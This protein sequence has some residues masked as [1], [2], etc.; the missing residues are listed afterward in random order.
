MSFTASF[1]ITRSNEALNAAT[2]TDTSVY[3]S[4]AKNTFSDRRLYLYRGDGTLIGPSAGV[5][6]WDFNYTDYPDDEITIDTLTEDAALSVVM[7]CTSIDPQPSSVYTATLVHLYTDYIQQFKYGLIKRM[8]AERKLEND[9]VFMSNLY[10][11][12]AYLNSAAKAVTYYD[13]YA[14]QQCIDNATYLI[15]NQTNFF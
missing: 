14:A 13:A 2:Y 9:V 4:E 7:V 5:D 15:T 8:A 3:G 12:Q 6:Y 10:I 1:T 11:M